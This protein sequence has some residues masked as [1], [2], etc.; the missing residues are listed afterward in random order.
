MVPGEFIT[1]TE[2]PFII[3]GLT[4]KTVF[5]IEVEQICD[6]PFSGTFI[7]RAL[8]HTSGKYCGEQVVDY[9]STTYPDIYSYETSLYPTNND[10]KVKLS[11]Y[12]V[13]TTAGTEFLNIYDGPNTTDPLLASYT[14]INPAPGPV[15]SSHPSGILTLK[16]ITDETDTVSL[17][18]YADVTC[19]PASLSLNQNS[20]FNVTFIPNPVRENLHFESNQ[21][22]LRIDLFDML[23]R[24]VG[25][26]QVNAYSGSIDLRKYSSGHY[27]AMVYSGNYIQPVRL[28][29]E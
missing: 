23:G 22:L 14:G 15:I 6:E 24:N 9:N 13:E 27:I 19:V 3:T 2:N 7:Y 17:G 16:Y 10:E 5:Q 21:E 18:Y 8:L 26:H 4:P 11:F 20:P 29:V 1:I 25:S 12:Y 28:I